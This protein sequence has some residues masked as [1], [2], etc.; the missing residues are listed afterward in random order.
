MFKLGLIAFIISFIYA[1]KNQMTSI[2][3]SFGAQAE[4]TAPL[5]SCGD[6]FRVNSGTQ[7]Y[8]ADIDRGDGACS[9][10]ITT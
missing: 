2:S 8:Q 10:F 3:E 6:T 4:E 1:E 9:I 7:E 5:K